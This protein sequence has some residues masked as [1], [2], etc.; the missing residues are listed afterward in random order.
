MKMTHESVGILAILIKTGFSHFFWK[1]RFH[2]K[3]FTNLSITET[4]N[5]KNSQCEALLTIEN[6]QLEPTETGLESRFSF[7]GK[8]WFVFDDGVNQKA[9]SSKTKVIIA[10]RPR[11]L[12][13]VDAKLQ[14]TSLQNL[15]KV[16]LPGENATYMCKL[17]YALPEP[18]VIWSI[19]GKIYDDE[20]NSK[21]ADIRSGKKCHQASLFSDDPDYS[22]CERTSRLVIPAREELNMKKIGCGYPGFMN[23]GKKKILEPVWK[24]FTMKVYYMVVLR[25]CHENSQKWPKISFFDL[26]I[27][28]NDLFDLKTGFLTENWV[29][30]PKNEFCWPENLL[31]IPK[32]DILAK[33]PCTSPT[34]PAWIFT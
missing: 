1:N 31:F 4:F 33:P 22:K 12:N 2:R 28:S 34:Q 17:A 29:F 30:D 23:Q 5:P 24:T 3:L 16:W 27:T 8:Y 21:E 6:T 26:K 32:F 9:T 7:Q 15:Q 11:R 25:K 10:L 19:D 14:A 18:K 13:F 20:S